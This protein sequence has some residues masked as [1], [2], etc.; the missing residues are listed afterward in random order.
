MIDI[1][2]SFRRRE[3]E[4]L[5]LSAFIIAFLFTIKSFLYTDLLDFLILLAIFFIILAPAFILHEISHKIV[6]IRLGYIAFYSIYPSALLW[7]ILL[8]LLFPGP[9]VFAA[10]GAVNIISLDGFYRKRDIEKISAAG[11]ITN[12]ILSIIFYILYKI[13]VFSGNSFDLPSIIL[14]YSSSLNIQLALFNLLPF[15]PLDGS[16]IASSNLIFYI[17][18]FVV[19]LLISFIVY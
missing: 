11:P 8:T 3:I 6:A 15:Y 19:T 10:T 17:T 7:S 1:I 18:L 4:E 2:K 13:A 14:R 9:T 12:I 16:K 5:L